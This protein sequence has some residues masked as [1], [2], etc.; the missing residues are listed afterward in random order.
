MDFAELKRRAEAGSCPAESVLGNF[1]LFGY[2]PIEVDYQEA[3]RFLTAAAKKGASRAIANL[4]YMYEEGLGVPKD[5]TKATEL[6]ERVGELEFFAAIALGRIYSKRSAT[7]ADQERAFKWY[8]VATGFDGRVSDCG[9]LNE[10]KA[11]VSKREPPRADR[12]QTA[13]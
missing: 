10:A 13:I 4:G 7:S 9:E 2:G 12:G 3:F 5:V 8:S 11:Y 6:Y 1:Y